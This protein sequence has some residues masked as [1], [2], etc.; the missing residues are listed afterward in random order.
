MARR[1]SCL[2]TGSLTGSCRKDKEVVREAL[3]GFGG[4]LKL[5]GLVLFSSC[6]KASLCHFVSGD[7]PFA[8][9][10]SRKELVLI[11]HGFRSNMARGTPGISL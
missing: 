5:Y 1:V 7:K 3:G 2:R 11:I 8:G 4:K 9:E 6:S 10:G